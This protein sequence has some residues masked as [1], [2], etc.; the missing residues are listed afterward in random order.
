MVVSVGAVP[1]IRGLIPGPEGDWQPDNPFLSFSFYFHI[2]IYNTSFPR[3]FNCLSISLKTIAYITHQ[4]VV[5]HVGSSSNSLPFY[6]RHRF[7]NPTPSPRPLAS[8]RHQFSRPQ[9][10]P[11]RRQNMVRLR[12][13]RQ[14]QACPSSYL[15][16]L[17]HMDAP[18]QGG[19]TYAGR[20]G[21]GS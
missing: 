16:R 6:N 7:S 4:N 10:R 5:F 17:Q 20:V 19:P 8:P 3:A 21:D 9:L 1:Y 11:S 12:H 18:R 2:Y 14:R 15:P 13:K